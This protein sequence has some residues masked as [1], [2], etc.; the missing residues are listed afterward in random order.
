MDHKRG[1]YNL[2]EAK[3]AD[4]C[5]KALSLDKKSEEAARVRD[6][7]RPKKGSGAGDMAA[8][9]REVRWRGQRPAWLV[10]ACTV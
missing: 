9:L 10:H 8:I 4:V 1:N 2:Q 7:K 6:W 5:L 3:L